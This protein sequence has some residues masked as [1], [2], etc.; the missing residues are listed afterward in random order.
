MKKR[1][2]DNPGLKQFRGARR[3]QSFL[4]MIE[5]FFYK[6][7]KVLMQSLGDEERKPNKDPFDVAWEEIVKA[8]EGLKRQKRKDYPTTVPPTRYQLEVLVGTLLGDGHIHKSKNILWID[9]AATKRPYVKW[10]YNT[11]KNVAGKLIETKRTRKDV[12]NANT[13]YS[14][15]FSTVAAFACIEILRNLF[16]EEIDRK[17]RKI[18]PRNIADLLT[19]VGLA[20]WYMDDGGKSQNTP[21]A[22]CFNVSSFNQDSRERLRETLAR[23]FKLDVVL[24]RAGVSKSGN[25]QW[26]LVV[27]TAS[28]KEFLRLVLPT[29]TEVPFILY[30]LG[31]TEQEAE[32]ILATSQFTELS[33]IEMKDL[34]IDQGNDSKLQ[35]PK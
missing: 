35:G 23:K 18:V 4:Q 22:V 27:R 1:L 14:I 9:Q 7:R 12:L 3:K 5:T 15:R 21:S 31:I 20:V 8:A 11:F 17:V 19:T 26:N 16:Y 10:L 25:E 30:K 24:N 33:L 28:F 6:K 32:L 34:A 29:L 13:T 2:I